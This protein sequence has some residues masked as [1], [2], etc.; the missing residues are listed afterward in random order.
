LY[1]DPKNQ[2]K[3]SK[4]KKVRV[5]SP[6]SH[7]KEKGNDRKRARVPF[8]ANARVCRR[9]K[10]ARKKSGKRSTQK[11]PISL[12]EVEEERVP[13]KTPPGVVFPLFFLVCRFLFFPMSR[14]LLLSTEL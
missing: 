9:A 4:I 1:A 6:I 11:T 10:E 3:K 12:L 13:K 5:H 2:E 7:K 14:L 8:K